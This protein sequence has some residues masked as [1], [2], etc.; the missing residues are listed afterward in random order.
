MFTKKSC[1]IKPL[2]QNLNNL[3]ILLI[4]SFLLKKTKKT[5]VKFLNIQ[6][7]NHIHLRINIYS[8]F[9]IRIYFIN[10]K[11]KKIM[12]K[13]IL[14][15]TIILLTGNFLSGQTARRVLIEEATNASCGPCGQQNPAFDAL[16]NQNSEHIAVVK[17]HASWP[18]YDPMYNH[19]TADNSARISYYS[20]NS[21]PRGV[22]DGTYNNMPSTF[23][24]ALINQYVSVP[25]PFE[26]EMFHYLSDDQ[27]SVYVFLRIKAAQDID[28]EGLKVHVAVVEKH[29]HFNTAPG[30]N[31][32]TDFYDVLKKLLPTRYGT[33]V[34]SAWQSGDYVILS[35]SWELANVYNIAE[36]GVVGFVQDTDTKQV[37]QS[38]NS[39]ET[40]F[41]A[42]FNNDASTLSVGNITETN[43]MG[44]ITPEIEFANYG[45]NVLTSVNIVCS[46]NGETSQVF[47]WTG[48]LGY[49]KTTKV[50]LPQIDFNLLSEN[51]MVFYLENPNG[52]P[53]EY[54]K[55]DS[56]TI[57]FDDAIETPYEVNLM[58]KFD[59]NPEE[60]TWEITNE[61]GAVIFAG[62]PYTQAGATVIEELVFET[63]GCY[64]FKIF[65]AGGDGLLSPG[66][67]ALYYGS[68]TQVIVGSQFGAMH[69]GQFHVDSYTGYQ[70]AQFTNSVKIFPNPVVDQATLVFD[71]FVAGK[72]NVEIVNTS[73][74]VV[75][76]IHN[77]ELLSEKHTAILSL[78]DLKKGFYLLKVI[79]PDGCMT[80]KLMITN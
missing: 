13:A 3:F 4:K 73:G 10:I 22:M 61:A 74:Q 28:D 36:L 66:F 17:Y 60:I 21:V 55:N 9:V 46:I 52:L 47:P 38:A 14:L 43:C 70:D 35:S 53:D 25:S 7:K 71:A 32:E 37:R 15:F 80:S 31:G 19:N 18:G 56:L 24:Q 44:F 34:P 69:Q 67:F 57:E 54:T 62:G 77:I 41:E 51:Q 11:N 42:L 64:L 30:N 27:D 16:L 26:M 68:G 48:N 50:Q 33:T 23:S 1:K 63:Q 72:V 78:G 45:A 59:D 65:D 40:P 5:C 49:L 2:F 39:E 76:T 29:I 79:S 6:M 8:I 12:R 75:K 58:I 20:I